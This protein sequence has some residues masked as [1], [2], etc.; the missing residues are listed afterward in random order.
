M[1][2]NNIIAVFST[3][4][5]KLGNNTI[6]EEQLRTDIKYLGNHLRFSCEC[7]ETL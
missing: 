5:Y 2:T 4:V 3:H 1:N 6:L 7:L